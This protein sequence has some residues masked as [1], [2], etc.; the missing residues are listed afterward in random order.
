MTCSRLKIQSLGISDLSQDLPVFTRDL[1]VKTWALL[2]TCKTTTLSPQNKKGMN[3]WRLSCSRAHNDFAHVTIKDRCIVMR[4]RYGAHTQPCTN[5]SL[6]DW[7]KVIG[8][9]LFYEFLIHR[10]LMFAKLWQS[11]DNICHSVWH[12]QS[13]E[14]ISIQSGIAASLHTHTHTHTYI[15]ASLPAKSFPPNP[16]WYDITAPRKVKIILDIFI[17]HPPF[18]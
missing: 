6:Q 11:I 5:W 17:I 16:F 15:I 14:L 4:A 13:P 1:L 9:L 18:I 2:V 8:W 10:S 7:S 12:H 3:M